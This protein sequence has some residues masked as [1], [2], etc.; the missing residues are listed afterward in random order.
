[1]CWILISVLFILGGD[2]C[3]WMSLQSLSLKINFLFFLQ[4][5]SHLKLFWI[6]ICIISLPRQFIWKKLASATA[7]L[8][9]IRCIKRNG[10]NALL[11]VSAYYL[12]TYPS[13][14]CMCCRIFRNVM[15]L[16]KSETKLIEI[17]MIHK[18]GNLI[19]WQDS[20]NT[21]KFEFML[22]PHKISNILLFP[23]LYFCIS[24]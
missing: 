23:F 13:L 5:A 2:T 12:H 21:F 9:M 8:S 4:W 7:F 20:G 18:T 15:R 19:E 11:I 10:A 24:D 22:M 6:H 3:P 1:M 14:C 16:E 17:Y